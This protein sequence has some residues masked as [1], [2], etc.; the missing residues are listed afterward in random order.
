LL[1]YSV[2]STISLAFSTSGKIKRANII[3]SILKKFK[4]RQYLQF[5]RA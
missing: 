2:K 5:I 4:N 1:F 3:L